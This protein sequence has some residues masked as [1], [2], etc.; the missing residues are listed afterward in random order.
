MKIL[1]N[2]VTWYSKL[3]AVALGIAILLLGIA[4]GVMYQR[5]LDAMEFAEQLQFERPPI[6]Q[7][8]TIAIY[9]FT[10]EGNIKNVATGEQEMDE[11]VLVYEAPGAPA[12]TKSLI[13]TT[14][15]KCAFNGAETFCDTSRF[16]QGQRVKVMGAEDGSGTVTVER[17]EVL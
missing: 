7:K 11:W 14:Q 12:L 17:M 4:A 5:G 1:W 9:G 3:L 8:K 15:S 2:K 6:V 13:F 16:E 10:Q